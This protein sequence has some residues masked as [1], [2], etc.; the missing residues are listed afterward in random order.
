[1]FVPFIHLYVSGPTFMYQSVY[2]WS[3]TSA[4]NTGSD[5]ASSLKLIRNVLSDTLKSVAVPANSTYMSNLYLPPSISWFLTD[6][7][8][9]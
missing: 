4:I 6:Q 8:V 7:I 3:S 5:N 9:S 2:A 1:M